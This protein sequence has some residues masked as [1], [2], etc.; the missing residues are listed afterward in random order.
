M[1]RAICAYLDVFSAGFSTPLLYRWKHAERSQQYISDG[2]ELHLLL[3][4]I[5]QH[6]GDGKNHDVLNELLAAAVASGHGSNEDISALEQVTRCKLAV[7]VSGESVVIF[8]VNF[9]VILN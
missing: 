7:L 5:L 4:K 3:P 2:V 1:H 6:M 8:S 9:I